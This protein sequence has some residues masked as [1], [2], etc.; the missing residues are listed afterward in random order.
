VLEISYY[1]AYRRIHGLFK[2]QLKQSTL[3]TNPSTKVRVR[4]FNKMGQNINAL[5]QSLER[6][7]LFDF[8]NNRDTI[9]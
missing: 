5:K 1:V 9:K 8:K 3:L 2:H 6:Y 7:E 4:F